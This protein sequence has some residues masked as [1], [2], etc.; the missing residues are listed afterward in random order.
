MHY[1]LKRWWDIPPL[2]PICFSILFARDVADIDFERSFELFSL[3]ETFGHCK[4]V[5]PSM[6]PVIMSM[7]QNGLKDVLYD[8]DDIDSPLS[9]KIQ[10]QAQ[11]ASLSVPSGHSRR[12]SMSLTKELESRR[13]CLK[14]VAKLVLTR[15]RDATA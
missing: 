2:W 5:Y 14:T 1:R 12:R 8:Q 15:C 7:L 10:P 11:K 13:M 9:E 4:V 3:L 6:L